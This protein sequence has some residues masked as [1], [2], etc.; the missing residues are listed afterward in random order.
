MQLSGGR[1]LEHGMSTVVVLRCGCAEIDCTSIRADEQGGTS[2]A[3]GN[4]WGSAFDCWEV[5]RDF[6]SCMVCVWAEWQS[7]RIRN[8]IHRRKYAMMTTAWPIRWFVL[9]LTL[10]SV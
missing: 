8:Q 10:C 9:F 7:W 5:G 1:G 3:V 4:A 6:M 2:V